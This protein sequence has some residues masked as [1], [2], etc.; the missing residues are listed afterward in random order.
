MSLKKDRVW[1]PLVHEHARASHRCAASEPT[2]EQAAE[3]ALLR[4]FT[5]IEIAQHEDRDPKDVLLAAERE[6]RRHGRP[7]DDLLRDWFRSRVL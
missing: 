3:R 1:F 7:V 5:A 4:E 2:I 6:A